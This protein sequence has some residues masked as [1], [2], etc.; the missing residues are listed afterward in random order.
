MAKYLKLLLW[1]FS[2]LYGG[3]TG[4]RNI[5]YNKGILKSTAYDMPVLA[6]GNLTVGGTGKTPHVEYLLRL[7]HKY[8]IA[9]L[10]RGYKRQTTGFILADATST[11]A[12]LGDEPY[13]YHLD[14]AD[15]AVAVCEK[16]VEG[17]DKLKA[18]VQD[19][20][21]VVLDDAMQHRA[22]RPSLMIMLTDYGRPFFR[23][24]IL[25]AGLL[26]ESRQGSKRAD[27]VVVSKCPQKLSQTERE[28]YVSNI[29]KYTLPGTP[30]FFSTFDY[31]KPVS[32]GVTDL[33]YKNIVLLT[34]IANPEPMRDYLQQQG[35]TIVKAYTFPDHHTYATDDLLEVKDFVSKYKGKDISIITTSKDAVKLTAPDLATISKQL[36]LFYLP[37]EVSFLEHAEKFNSI[38]SEHVNQK[39]ALKQI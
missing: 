10:S 31:G 17:V 38:I 14:F 29:S 11:A 4:L 28:K 6:V 13:Q 2:L 35:Y 30:V 23:D 20:E 9:T 22:I 7:L 21:V 8:K 34:G 18:S 39:L 5:L 36:P 3:V 16:R 25:P 26:R 37:I 27:V 32:V 1:P 24:F 19:L 12:Q 15:V 33:V